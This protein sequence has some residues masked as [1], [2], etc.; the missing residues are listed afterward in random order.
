MSIPDNSPKHT[1]DDEDYWARLLKAHAQNLPM[2]EKQMLSDETLKAI[3]T[4][5]PYPS[6]IA[7][8]S[9]SHRRSVRKLGNTLG[10]L[11]TIKQHLSRRNR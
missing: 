5:E 8:L 2:P 6:L 10:K 11:W 7:S 3:T 4:L 9:T 1:P